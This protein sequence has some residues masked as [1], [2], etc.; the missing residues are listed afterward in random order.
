M[1]S[2]KAI[3]TENTADFL[4]ERIVAVLKADRT[5]A[6][7]LRKL[8]IAYYELMKKLVENEKQYFSTTF[9]R[10]VFF[11]DKY[12][13][14]SKLDITLKKTRRILKNINQNSTQDEV[15]F[16]AAV[17]LDTI[18]FASKLSLPKDLQH[19]KNNLKYQDKDIGGKMPAQTIAQSKAIISEKGDYIHGGTDKHEHSEIIIE[20]SEYGRCRLLLYGIW[21]ELW[22]YS[23]KGAELN[24]FAI[25]VLSEKKKI[26]GTTSESI[27][28]LEPDYL[29]DATE[30]AECFLISGMNMYLY[31]FK[32]FQRSGSGFPLV[33]GNMVNQCFDM[34]L[35]NPDSDLESIYETALK[36]RPLQS[37]AIAIKD[38]EA[39]K[40]LRPTLAKHFRA[41]RKIAK[42]YA[43]MKIS[44]EPS[45]I[46]PKYGLQGRLDALIEYEEDTS[47]KD[48]IE[49]KSG[50]APNL[51]FSIRNPDG[52]RVPVG[53]WPNHF[54]QTTC[55]NLLL[56]STFEERT[57]SSLILYSKDEDNPLRNSPNI[58]IKKQEVAN[59]RN[60]II[61][62]DNALRN[63]IHTIFNDFTR[64]RF[65][66]KPPYID[67]DLV[68]FSR[69]YRNADATERKY[70]NAYVSFLF[71]E[72]H[73]AKLGNGTNNGKAG[74]SALWR[75]SLEDKT[76]SHEALPG[77]RIIPEECNLENL[78]LSFF[79]SPGLA[80]SSSFRKGDICILYPTDGDASPL[81][82]QLIK[83]SIRNITPEK[84]FLSLRNK[85][86][87]K[88][89]FQ[90]YT[91]W[92]IEPDYIDSTLKKQIP[93]LYEFF[94]LEKIKK[95]LLLG[96]KRPQ[97]SKNEPDI[98]GE[99]NEMQQKL[100]SKAV[101]T[102]HYFLLQGPPGTGKTSYMLN[103][104][105]NYYYENTRSDILVLAYTNR[106][107]DEICSALKKLSPDFPF[108][109]LGTKESSEHEDRLISRLADKKP[110]RELYK[111]VIDTRIFC[112]TVSSVLA[113]QEIF[114][115]KKFS[116]AV[117]DEASQILEPQ[118]VGIVSQVE[119]FILIGDE[120]QLPAVVVQNGQYN[121]IDDPDLLEIGLKDLR[122][123]LFERLLNNCISKGWHEA[124]GMLDRQARMHADIQ[125]FPNET[126]YGSRLNILG[127]GW[128]A[129]GMQAF[130]NDSSEPLEKLLASSR[131]LF[132]ESKPE[133]SGKINFFEAAAAAQIALAIEKAYGDDFEE[134]T[135]GIIAPFRA[136][137]A[138]IYRQLHP[139][140]RKNVMVET[141][142]RFQGSERDVIIFSFAVNH[143]YQLE[144]VS[145]VTE[146]SGI[147]TDRKLNVAMTRARK[148]LIFLGAAGI[149]KQS[150]IPSKLIDYAGSCGAFIDYPTISGLIN[151]KV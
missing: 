83:C 39:T 122:N 24:L 33:L 107:V 92:V 106:A 57:G 48:V 62:L 37:F 73:A 28:V 134:K 151:V 61:A 66:L 132:F 41:L 64:D 149:L 101:N 145:S 91:E 131:I 99:L 31:F 115:I 102:R 1:P 95:D 12:K 129:S 120:K 80:V 78:H 141:V 8:K 47:R 11:L 77:L 103:N 96:K 51:E 150:E 54:A 71:R 68:E 25:K 130:N 35:E 118:L 2:Q 140:L 38:P 44:V 52:S 53:I 59:C 36:I 46:S 63:N 143:S 7:S 74:F 30:I 147:K 135:L 18:V 20:S 121:K 138:E 105:V 127:A 128:Q 124:Y 40:R 60:W 88:D 27:I 100:Y 13:P 84:V 87:D 23:W 126:F 5:P 86:L 79:I 32:K 81:S 117:V 116:I 67:S 104:I 50:K 49:L 90:K 70:F 112:S 148:H 110:L 89:F 26:L 6:E 17:I 42:E 65:G 29:V 114:D 43:G 139:H 119:R 133:R 19:I 98:L 94:K 97:F 55:Y 125:R 58:I 109:R 136:Q 15:V 45:F 34:L 93:S 113:N 75:H 14:P 21:K 9:S 123:S 69:L 3:I 108:L 76:S 142:E 137:C 85:L 111:D 56:D 144:Q 4:C 10:M 16:V 72:I 82:R 22:K 146:V